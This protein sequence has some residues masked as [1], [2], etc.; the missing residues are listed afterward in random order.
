MHKEKEESGGGKRAGVD[1]GM[2]WDHG[3]RLG[4]RGGGRKKKKT[5]RSTASKENIAV[6][7]NASK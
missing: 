3:L 5:A 1:T 2:R 4:G 7:V 6:S